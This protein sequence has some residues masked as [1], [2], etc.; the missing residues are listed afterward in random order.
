MSLHP[1]AYRCIPPL[2]VDIRKQPW[3]LVH[4][5][6]RG[7]RGHPR[8]P[9]HL[10]LPSSSCLSCLSRMEVGRCHTDPPPQLTVRWS[11][12]EAHRA[13][14]EAKL[15]REVPTVWGHSHVSERKEVQVLKLQHRLAWGRVHFHSRLVQRKGKTKCRRQNICVLKLVRK[16]YMYCG[17]VLS[18]RC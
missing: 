8:S 4:L 2:W 15:L 14:G 6:D 1:K 16:H 7:H 10:C 5:G 12:A 3:G 13:D 11:L 18:V 17:A 9:L